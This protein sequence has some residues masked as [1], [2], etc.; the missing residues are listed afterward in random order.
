LLNRELKL[1]ER[2]GHAARQ[3]LDSPQALLAALAEQFGLHFPA[4]TRFGSGP[5]P[6][7]T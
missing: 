7:P 6:W 2:D 5:S 3:E 1:R 4:G